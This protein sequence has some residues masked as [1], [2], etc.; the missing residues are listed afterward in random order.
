M[1]RPPVL[2]AALDIRV[3]HGRAD[4]KTCIQSSPS[5][6]SVCRS[7]VVRQSSVISQSSVVRVLG[8][9]PLRGL[10]R[11]RAGSSGFPTATG[12]IRAAR[13]AR[14]RRQTR[15]KRNHHQHT[16][17]HFSPPRSRM[18]RRDTAWRARIRGRLYSLQHVLL[19]EMRVQQLGT[20]QRCRPP[21]PEPNHHHLAH[22]RQRAAVSH[23][24]THTY[25][26]AQWWMAAAASP[27]ERHAPSAA[28]APHP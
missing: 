10:W 18:A 20:G 15:T 13:P 19:P 7:A 23:Q 27:S 11:T 26:P 8:R 2:P 1:R 22:H 14:P 3:L 24:Q 17:P 9:A 16:S 12:C 25:L 4:T 28:R 21:F 6:E 5:S